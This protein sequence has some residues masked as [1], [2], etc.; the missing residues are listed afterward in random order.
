MDDRTYEHA[1]APAEQILIEVAGPEPGAR[2]ILP[3]GAT[4][5]GRSLSN[6]ITIDDTRISRHHLKI[7]RLPS[8]IG[9]A[10]CR[11]RVCVGV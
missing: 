6:E 1:D 2:Y 8:E 9:R 7:E 5:I 11:E 4:T 3:Q 10:S